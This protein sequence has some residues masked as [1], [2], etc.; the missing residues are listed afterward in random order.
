MKKCFYLVVVFGMVTWLMIQTTSVSAKSPIVLKGGHVVSTQNYMHITLVKWSDIVKEKTNGEVI[1]EVYPSEQL[2]D[3]RALLENVNMGTI[4]WCSVGSGGAAR[5]APFFGMFEN[6]Y[7][8]KNLEHFQKVV[9][10]RPF[11]QRLSQSLEQKS[12]LVLCGFEWL[13]SRHFLSKNPVRK[14]ED[15]KGMRLR[16]PDVPTYK[17][18]AHAVGAIATPIPFGESFMAL[19]Q[20]VVDAIEGT[21]ENIFVRKFYEAAKNYTLT[22]HMIQAGAV[23]MNKNV[24]FNKLSEKHQKVVLDSAYEAWLWCFRSYDSVEKDYLKKIEEAGTNV[25]KLT[26]TDPFRKR[27]LEV[28][29]EKYIP[30]W[31]K[32]WDEFDALGK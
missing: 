26:S 7:T 3:E 20:G 21:P 2:G 4:D 31:G 6:A 18:V 14:P 5:F 32:F 28:L 24:F 23:F 30:Q 1:I 25:I 22:Y 19:K 10:N 17:V 9:F 13:G 11:I 16:I 15:A 8:F 27:A 29:E 12:N